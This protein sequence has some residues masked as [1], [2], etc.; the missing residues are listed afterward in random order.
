MKQWAL[1]YPYL[2]FVIVLCSIHLP[3][4]LVKGFCRMVMVLARGWPTQPLMDADGDIVHPQ[5]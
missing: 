5:D 4:N 2:T 1:N 3:F